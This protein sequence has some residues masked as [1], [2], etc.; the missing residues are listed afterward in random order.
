MAGLSPGSF[1]AEAFPEQVGHLDEE[2]AAI[3]AKARLELSRERTE[4][5]ASEI[6]V[7]P[8]IESRAGIWRVAE[9][10]LAASVG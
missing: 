2:G 3:A 5:V 9:Q 6:V 7:V 1:P 4:A 8:D 10:K